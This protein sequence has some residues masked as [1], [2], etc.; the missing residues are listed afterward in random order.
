M[1]FNLSATSDHQFICPAFYKNYSLLTSYMFNEF[2]YVT[3][4]KHF[5][6]YIISIL[7]TINELI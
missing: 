2:Y 4:R 7:P 5:Q 3:V 6:P 1:P